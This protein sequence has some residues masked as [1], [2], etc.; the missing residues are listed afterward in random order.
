MNNTQR[1]VFSPK[2]LS[3]VLGGLLLERLFFSDSSWSPVSFL[4]QEIVAL[5]AI[6]FPSLSDPANAA[7][8][9]QSLFA[10][11]LVVLGAA[12]LWPSLACAVRPASATEARS[13]RGLGRAWRLGIAGKLTVYFCAVGLAFGIAACRIVNVYYPAVFERE[14]KRRVDIVALGLSETLAQRLAADGGRVIAAEVERYA[15]IKAVAYVFVEDAG[16]RI[17][18]Q[19]PAGLGLAS[20]RDLPQSAERSLHGLN[21]HFGGA[22]VFEIAKR[23]G[24]GKGYVHLAIWRAA[25]AEEARLAVAPIAGSILVALL[26]V[27]G[28]FIFR[29][30]RMTR[31][32]RALIEPVD[33][34]SRGEFAVALD[35]KDSDEVGELARAFDRLRS[36]LSAAMR[37][38]DPAKPAAPTQKPPS[39]K[40][41]P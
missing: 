35:L 22:E 33:K 3:L 7:V 9:E 21:L 25:I 17:I 31:P 38:F 27:A 1:K 39:Q 11:C 24:D 15:S 5:M 29:V 36:S 40:I 41:A 37:R 12:L 26:G 8:L 4:S 10:V 16:G 18:A 20:Q 6:F 14:I 19:A 32:Y 23:I 34:I 2:A 28:M 30:R 13:A